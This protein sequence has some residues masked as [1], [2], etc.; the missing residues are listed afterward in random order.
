MGG[1]GSL[2]P[3]LPLVGLLLAAQASAAEALSLPE[4]VRFALEHNPELATLRQ[5]HGIA[6]AAVVIA[7]TYP[8]NPIGQ[9]LVTG[10]GGGT[11]ADIRNRV[12]NEHLVRIDVECRGQGKHRTAAA[13]AALSRTEWEIA[14]RETDLAIRLIRAFQAVIYQRERLRFAEA[15]QKFQEEAVARSQRLFEQGLPVRGELLLARADLGEARAA[16]GTTRATLD[17]ATQALR[18]LLGVIDEEVVVDG[19]LAVNI[20]GADAGTLSAVAV[21]NRPDVRALRLAVDEAEARLRL[22]VANRWGNPSVGPAFELNETR[23]YF[24]GVYVVLPIAICNTRQG[25]ILQR[26]AER[27]RAMLALRQAEIQL[28]QDIRAALARLADAAA[29][30]KAYHDETLPALEEM[31]TTLDKLFNEAAPG[32]NLGQVLEVRRRILRARGLYLDALW[33]LSQA[34]TDLAAALGDPTA[35]WQE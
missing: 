16:V 22:E 11:A 1:L 14:A 5:Q 24:T 33:E 32:V 30:V 4:A 23:A 31:R 20:P 25:D 7:R 10:V 15:A 19:R 6:A 13:Q 9:S 17:Q 3:L 35:A 21:E 18:R 2:R 34:Q 26:K 12:F 27:E 8:F 29:V 28:Q